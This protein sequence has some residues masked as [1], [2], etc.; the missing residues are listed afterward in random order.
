MLSLLTDLDYSLKMS[1]AEIERGFPLGRRFARVGI[2]FCL[3]RLSVVYLRAHRCCRRACMYG[4]R[5]NYSG[6]SNAHSAIICVSSSTTQL[7]SQ[8][9]YTNLFIKRVP[10]FLAARIGCFISVYI[11]YIYIYHSENH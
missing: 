2:E 3:D 9:L 8:N 1:T 10:L 4:P 6:A 11:I 7:G 5:D